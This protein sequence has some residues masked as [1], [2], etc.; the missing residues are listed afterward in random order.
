MKNIIRN[1]LDRRGKKNVAILIA[2]FLLFVTACGS[3]DV[4]AG[5]EALP[6]T[7]TAEE[8]KKITGSESDSMRTPFLLTFHDAPSQLTSNI[9]VLSEVREIRFSRTGWI[10]RDGNLI[11]APWCGF[12]ILSQMTGY[13]M[14]FQIF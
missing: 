11:E 9:E 12:G 4:Q 2:V 5:E 14:K 6:S 13:E 8:N 7:E 10:I 3:N 1:L